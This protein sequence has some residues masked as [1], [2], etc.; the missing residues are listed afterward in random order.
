MSFWHLLREAFGAFLLGV[1]VF[2]VLALA[3]F[4]VL[5]RERLRIRTAT[6]LYVLSLVGLLLAEILVVNGANPDGS[7]YRWTRW[8]SLLLQGIALIS[9]ASIFIFDILLAALHVPPPRIMRDLL[10][11][12]AYILLPMIYNFAP[13][14][15]PNERRWLTPGAIVGVA[16]W[17]LVSFGFRV[18]L[19]YFNSYSMTYGS[20]GALIVLMLW[21]Y[22]TGAAILIGGEV[23][24]EAVQRRQSDLSLD[25]KP[26]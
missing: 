8:A 11:A 26:G 15:Q 25:R 14:L 1:P 19:H 24:C 18:Y 13:N 12:F 20:L 3:L 4:A 5:P 7:A 22:F 16:L 23:N 2:I 17:L 6:V 10:L 9:I 21:F